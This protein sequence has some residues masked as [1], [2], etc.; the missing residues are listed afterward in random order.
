MISL[1][2]LPFIISVL[3]VGGVF[4]GFYVS[5]VTEDSNRLVYPLIFST[6]G[7]AVSIVAIYHIA[8]RISGEAQKKV[9]V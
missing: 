3:V 6:L 8:R 2:L 5:E 1:V 4:L 9:G 7:L